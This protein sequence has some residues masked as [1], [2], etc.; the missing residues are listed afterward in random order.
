MLILYCYC[1]WMVG[2]IIASYLSVQVS[3]IALFRK[4]NLDYLCAARTAPCHSWKNT[5]ERIMS[6]FNLGLQSVGLMQESKDAEYEK[7][8][9]RF[10]KF[11]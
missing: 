6:T 3:L 10:K 7:V 5:V 2:L 1:I 4:L 11:V 8:A 9:E